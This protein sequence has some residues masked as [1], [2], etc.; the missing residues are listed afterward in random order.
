M[1]S[2]QWTLLAQKLLEAQALLPP[3]RAI[4]PVP[5][6]IPLLQMHRRLSNLQMQVLKLRDK[7]KKKV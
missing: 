4:E 6:S 7:S 5:E 2:E 1:T 3:L